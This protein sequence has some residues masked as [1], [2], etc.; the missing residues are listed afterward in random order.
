MSCRA[1]R[2]VRLRFG[3]LVCQNPEERAAVSECTYLID[4][5][6][7]YPLDGNVTVSVYGRKVDWLVA[8]SAQRAP[9]S[10]PPGVPQA[11]PGV[12]KLRIWTSCSLRSRACRA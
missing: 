3:G 1:S 8:A 7:N 2:M 5:A 10:P 6:G 4:G 11:C 9:K 12:A